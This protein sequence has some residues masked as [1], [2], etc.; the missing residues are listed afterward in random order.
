M[1]CSSSKRIEAAI[2]DVYCLVVTSFTVLDIYAIE[3]PWL[4]GDHASEQQQEKAMHVPP[5]VLEKLNALK[6]EPCS[7]DE[8]SRVLEDLKP[9]LHSPAPVVFGVNPFG[10]V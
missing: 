2:V 9:M 4:K 6:D 10:L 3:E 7:W 5:L 8:V 1:G